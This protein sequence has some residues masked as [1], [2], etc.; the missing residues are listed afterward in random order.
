VN[1]ELVA[2]AEYIMENMQREDLA[3]LDVRSDGEWT[4]ANTRG[5]KRG[6]HMPGAVHLEWL[7]YVTDDDIQQFKPA[8]ELRQMFTTCGIT[9]EKEVVTY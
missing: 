8:E 9:P 6:G 3:L 4:G 2:S 7:N 1:P 5:N